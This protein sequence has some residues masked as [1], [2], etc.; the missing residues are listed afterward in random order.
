MPAPAAAQMQNFAKIRFMSFGI[1]LATDWETPSGDPAGD[2]YVKAF[3]PDELAGF[4]VPGLFLP[5][6]T[7]VYHVDT[8][9]TISD[10]FEKY[11]DGICAAICSA[12][13]TWQSTAGMVGVV[14]NAV[15]ATGGQVLGPSW[16]PLI[17]AG[18]PKATPQES[19]YSNAIAGA[20]G[21]GWQSYT[22]TMI[23]PGLPWYPAFAAFPAP[24]APPTPNVPSPLVALTQVTSSIS[25]SSLKSS[26]V[27]LLGD[28]KALHHEELF[29]AI[30]TAFEQCF[31]I[32][33]AATVISNVLGTGPV[34]TFAPP[35]V[36]VGPV[37]GGTAVGA[38]GTVFI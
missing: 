28:P 3:A 5:A 25:K 8:A 10:A 17:M 6:T 36:P 24:V 4:P 15:T 34:P 14:V 37:V 20:V 7:N 30:A 16:M 19:K 23:V 27:G 32:W 29:D 18:A 26:M 31:L 11:I 22:S 12:W 13:S 9:K 1:K 38:P 33:H 35:Y 2:H 21:M